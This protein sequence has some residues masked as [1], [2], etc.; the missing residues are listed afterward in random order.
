MKEKEGKKKGGHKVKVSQ[1]L[2]DLVNYCKTAH[3]KSFEQC[4]EKG[5]PDQMSSFAEAKS[6]KLSSGQRAEFSM[7][8]PFSSFFLLSSFFLATISCFFDSP[9]L[10]ICLLALQLSTT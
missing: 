2:S 1:E 7:I 10:F 3:F 5:R 8:P 4:K 6:E 9:S